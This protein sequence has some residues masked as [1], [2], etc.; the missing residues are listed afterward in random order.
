MRIEGGHQFRCDRRDLWKALQD[1]ETLAATLPGI[2][3]LEVVGPD[4]YAVTANIGVGS[5]TGT[6]EGTFSVEERKDFES[7]VLRGSARGAPGAVQVEA[8]TWFR[9][10]AGG[11]TALSY[12][13]DASVS[14][15]IAGVGQRMIAAAARRLGEQF[16]TA[17]DDGLIG[18]E[19]ATASAEEARPSERR[20]LF[21]RAPVGGGERSFVAGMLV[22]FALALIGVAVGRR[23]AR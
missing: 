1:P 11:G 6:Y 9:D 10:G 2:R 16:F 13:A 18:D 3:R 12:E 22:G 15:A 17:L 5:V 19:R 8:R 7:C 20:R 23:S 21:F 14:G 4:R